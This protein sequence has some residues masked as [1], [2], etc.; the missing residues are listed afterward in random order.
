[1]VREMPY[2]PDIDPVDEHLLSVLGSLWH[3]DKAITVLEAMNLSAHLSNT[4][5]HRRLMSLRMKGLIALQVSEF[6][7]RVK[8]VIP[9]LLTYKYFA[10]LGSALMSAQVEGDF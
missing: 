3:Q 7:C 4:T 9:T 2:F 5:Q 10:A 6:D 1:M 8:H